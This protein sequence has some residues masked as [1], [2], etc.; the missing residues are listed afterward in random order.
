MRRN[1]RA[2]RSISVVGQNVIDELA[3]R[4]TAALVLQAQIREISNRRM[5]IGGRRAQSGQLH[6]GQI[7]DVVADETDTAKRNGLSLGNQ[8]QGRGFLPAAGMQLRDGH[9]LGEK[10]GER[11]DL[12]GN[13]PEHQAGLA[14]DRYSPHIKEAEALD[15]KSTRLNSSHG[16]ISYAV[17]CLK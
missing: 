9:S 3:D 12:A 13:Q 2:S 5:G 1:R 8:A 10:L 4:A 16:Y 6:G 14:A 11:R 7:V 15:R 17:F